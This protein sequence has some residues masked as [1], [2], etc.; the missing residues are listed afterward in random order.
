MI[1][2]VEVSY[3]ASQQLV[4]LG[5]SENNPGVASLASAVGSMAGWL[6]YEATS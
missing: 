1:L 6:G 2:L 4:G 3:W 5:F